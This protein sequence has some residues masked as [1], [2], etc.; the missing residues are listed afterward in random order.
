MAFKKIFQEPEFFASG[1]LSIGVK[2]EKP[3]KYSGDNT[4]VFFIIEGVANVIIQDNEFTLATGGCFHI[5][6]CKFKDLF[7]K[8]IKF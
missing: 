1:M 7:L 6:R 2:E 4:Y 3:E 5:P 8:L